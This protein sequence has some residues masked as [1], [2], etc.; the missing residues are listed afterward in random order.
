MTG[1]SAV[2]PAVVEI[3][4]TVNP[5]GSIRLELTRRVKISKSASVSSARQTIRNWSRS[6]S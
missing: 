4:T 5:P 2:P 3:G 1:S 6:G